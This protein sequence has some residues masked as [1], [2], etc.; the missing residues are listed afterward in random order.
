MLKRDTTSGRQEEEGGE[1]SGQ[2]DC[3]CPDLFWPVVME[4]G[5]QL[6]L[7]GFKGFKEV[8]GLKGTGKETEG[9]GIGRET[10]RGKGTWNENGK[11]WEDGDTEKLNGGNISKH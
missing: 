8:Q 5:G 2:L 1:G 10:G 11:K 6:P 3:Q 9:G 4:H 7:K